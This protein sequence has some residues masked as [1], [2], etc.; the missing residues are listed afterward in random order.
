MSKKAET[1]FEAYQT[2]FKSDTGLTHNTNYS[3]FLEYVKCRIMDI[4]NKNLAGISQS[5]MDIG[6]ELR[7][8]N[9]PAKG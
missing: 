1:P 4:Q 6:E 7:L 2:D 9:L 8:S 3:L 5:L